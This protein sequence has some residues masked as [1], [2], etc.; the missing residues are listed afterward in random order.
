MAK[1]SIARPC[2]VRGRRDWGVVFM[3]KLLF[4][5]AA[6]AAL[7]MAS[8]AQASVHTLNITWSGAQFGNQ[9]SAT[10]VLTFDDAAVPD[11]GGS[12]ISHSMSDLIDFSMDIT[13]TAGGLGDGHFTVADFSSFVFA[14]NSALDYNHELIGQALANGCTFGSQADG[15]YG[16]PSGD[17]NLFTASNNNA[18]N[19]TFYF[20]LTA[21][22]GDNL[23]V[24]SIA[25]GAVPEPMAWALMIGGFGLAGATLRLRRKV[26]FAA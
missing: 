12:Q 2:E 11:L 25:P 20:R 16:G 1:L 24:T 4:G 5:A 9:A 23:F 14:A 3:R 7:M 17:F 21:V 26:S 18:P 22:G 8:A 15:C 10:G 13:G 6:A 19:G